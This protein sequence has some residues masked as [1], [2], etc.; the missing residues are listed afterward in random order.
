MHYIL[1]NWIDQHLTPNE[2]DFEIDLYDEISNKFI[3]LIKKT[4]ETYI[5][6]SYDGEKLKVIHP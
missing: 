5:V 1:Q 4:N 3:V 6:L 2:I